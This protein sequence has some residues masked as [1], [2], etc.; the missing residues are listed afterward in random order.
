VHL[1]AAIIAATL[2][3][4]AGQTGTAV[5]GRSQEQP[6]AKAADK[7]SLSDLDAFMGRVLER[8]DE[9]W[10][11]LHDYILGER[12]GFQI[13][14]PGD[15]PMY[16][17]KREYAWYVREGFLVRSP[18]RFD[19]VELSDRE[20]REYEEKWLQQE[21]DREKRAQERAA[22]ETEGQPPD[23]EKTV[24]AIGPG[25]VSVTKRP[26][27]AAGDPAPAANPPGTQ[28][29]DPSLQDIIPERGEP[30]FI[31]EAYFMR[32]KFEPGN[33]YLVGREK[34]DGHEVLRIEYYPTR[35]FSDD[36]KQEAE[37]GTG[38]K[39]AQG[40][41]KRRERQRERDL[42]REI[43]RKM[44]KASLV[45]LWVD[46]AAYQIVKYTFDN[47]DFG[48]LP[49]RWLVRV[50]DVSASMTMARVF[51]DVWLPSRITMSGAF[52]LA[53]GGYRIQYGREFSD[54]KKAETGARIRSY[55]PKVPR[56]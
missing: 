21:K 3:L 26:A 56:P 44:N 12:E 35:L 52:S 54:Y 22:K 10:R 28:E 19:G 50:D 1:R 43:E 6:A 27:D 15:I 13:L 46:P 8:R 7:A 20:R 2:V 48:F 33:Y 11:K 36:R 41:D 55:I 37:A 9:S 40:K 38:E 17:M 14:G 29:S 32:F 5:E 45:T 39:A 42:E 47:V 31:S 25:G 49:G 16:G 18:V 51:E 4:T 30:R 23:K 34:L 24:V 53:S